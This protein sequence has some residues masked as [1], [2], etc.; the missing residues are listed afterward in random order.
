[1]CIRDRDKNVFL[2]D[3][4]GTAVAGIICAEGNNSK[5]FTGLNWKIKAML[6]EV[7]TVEDIVS[8]YDY[9]YNI[10]QK[11]DASSGSKGSFVVATSA[12]LGISNAFPNVAPSYCDAIGLVSNIGVLNACATTN[13]NVN[14][15]ITGDLPSLC[16]A[17]NMIVV[18]STKRDDSRY[19]LL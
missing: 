13:S 2:P 17:D 3:S 9:V 4:H 7:A 16:T 14:I 10:R 5:G 8:A 12:S 6:L 15:D 1:M 19:C 11:Y 18:N